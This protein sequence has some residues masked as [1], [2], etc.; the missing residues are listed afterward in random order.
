MN[1]VIPFYAPRYILPTAIGSQRPLLSLDYS[2]P[3]VVLTGA[4]CRFGVT[5]SAQER[6]LSVISF[7][8][9]AATKA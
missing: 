8:F 7:D 3:V 5:D 4:A 2:M 9:W 1:V 6:S